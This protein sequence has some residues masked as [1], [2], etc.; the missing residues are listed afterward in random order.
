MHRSSIGWL[1]VYINL[2]VCNVKRDYKQRDLLLLNRQE[3]SQLKMF[4]KSK[5]VKKDDVSTI[6]LVPSNAYDC[7]SQAG[8]S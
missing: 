3:P 4:N 5:I 8:H 6:D 7:V 2:C 1:F